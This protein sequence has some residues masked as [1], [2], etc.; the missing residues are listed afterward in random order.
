[1]PRT[2]GS[3]ERPKSERS[4][5]LALT[6]AAVALASELELGALL[7]RIV[8]VARDLVG[9]K[10]AALG[11]WEEGTIVQF[12]FAGLDPETAGRQEH[13]PVGKGILGTVLS[14]G[15]TIRI[16]NLTRDPRAA[17]FPAG[18]PPMRSF[19]GVPIQHRGKTYGD[20]YLTEKQGAKTFSKLDEELTVSLASLAAVAIENATLFAREHETVDRLSELDRMRAD[21]VSMVSHELRNPISTIRGFGLLLRDRI[22]ILSGEER[23]EFTTAVVRQADRLYDLVEDVLAVSRIDRG[24][25]SYAFLPYQPA[26]LLE[27]CVAETQAAFPEHTVALEIPSG[28]RLTRGDR[29]RMKQVVANL[30]QNAC[31]YSAEGTTVTVLARE[32]GEL[33]EVSVAD[34]GIGIG[35]KDLP[36]L[37]QRFSRIRQPGMEQVK[38]TGLGLYISRR[39][40]ESHG[41][42]IWAESDRRGSTFR[43]SVPVAGPAPRN[44]PAR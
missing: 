38:G 4:R 24:E 33:L 32:Q 40:I 31:R 34:Q 44:D 30:L 27:E 39:I 3:V 28:L 2:P 35:A 1:M 23:R 14:E 43:F 12:A 21:F 11:V 18:H 7:Q 16:S 36:R 17:G 9:A 19:L 29:D 6:R 42:R 15:R 13:P 25:F 22:E 20:L 26:D 8:E 37:F 41:G 5:L 10:Y